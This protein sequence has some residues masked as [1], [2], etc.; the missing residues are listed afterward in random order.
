MYN[1]KYASIIG[2]I[3]FIL[4]ISLLLFIMYISNQQDNSSQNGSNGKDNNEKI[5][6][7]W[8]VD[9][10]ELVDK[11]LFQ[12]VKYNYGSPEVWGRYLGD[13]EDVSEGI[14]ADEVDYLHD[15]DVKIL[16]IYNH[17]DSATG[18]DHGADHASKA[19]NYAK[20]LKVP[21]DVALFGDIEPNFSVDSAF[22]EGWYDTISDSDFAP[23]LYGVFNKDSKLIEA[24]NATNEKYQ[25]NIVVWS[26]YPQKEIS[27]KKEAP[28][29]NPDGPKDAMTNGWQYGQDSEDCHID[30]NL[31][32]DDMLDYLW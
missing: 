7:Y 2:W 4:V 26:A 11:D 6:P 12:C 24:Y 13:I 18:Y 14:D 19:I 23:G 9:S 32:N 3:I 5:Y 15:K 10:A 27:S 31:F 20:D 28:E 8:G 29:F 30:T 21:D 17:F 1:K 22:I 25:K 16:L